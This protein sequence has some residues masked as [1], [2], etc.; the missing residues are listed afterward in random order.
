MSTIAN[1]K[2]K[3]PSPS[4]EETPTVVQFKETVLSETYQVDKNVKHLNCILLS[5][6]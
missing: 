1:P 3:H 6:L 2:V 5:H 4:L